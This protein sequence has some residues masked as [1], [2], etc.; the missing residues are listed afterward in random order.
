[1]VFNISDK[2]TK[3]FFGKGDIR[4]DQGLIDYEGMPRGLIALS[5]HPKP[6]PIGAYE[7]E[8]HYSVDVDQTPVIMMF[9]KISSIDVLINQLQ[10]CKDGMIQ[11]EIGTE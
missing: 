4:V 11:C 8:E 7:L 5:N 10:K 6:M 3:C 2:N 1:M 9:D